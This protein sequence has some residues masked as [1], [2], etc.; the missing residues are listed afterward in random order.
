MEEELILARKTQT[1]DEDTMIELQTR[2]GQ[3][4]V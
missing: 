4:V 2:G 1:A 3:S